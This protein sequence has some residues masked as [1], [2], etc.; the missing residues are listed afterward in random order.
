MVGCRSKGEKEKSEKFSSQALI[1]RAALQL[2]AKVPVASMGP[3]EKDCMDPSS[4][5]LALLS[6]R[7][8]SPADEAASSSATK[9]FGLLSIWRLR[10]ENSFSHCTLREGAN[11]EEVQQVAKCP[12]TKSLQI[13]TSQE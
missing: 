2:V 4:R 12:S 13:T 3:P 9:R 8:Y 11:T 1:N 7:D 10:S 6:P 5:E